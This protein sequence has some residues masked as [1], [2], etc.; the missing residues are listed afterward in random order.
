MKLRQRA[1]HPV[2]VAASLMLVAAAC[3]RKMPDTGNEPESSPKP[4]LQ[5]PAE[6]PSVRPA[7]DMN[8]NRTV[9]VLVRKMRAPD[10]YRC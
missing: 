3:E 10:R 8:R 7:R 2:V 4:Q 9:L 6:K 1:L 5:A